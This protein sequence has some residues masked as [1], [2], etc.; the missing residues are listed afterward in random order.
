MLKHAVVI[1]EL[2]GKTLKN[3]ITDISLQ[4]CDIKKWLEALDIAKVLDLGNNAVIVLKT[5]APE[6]AAP[7]SKLF[8]YNHNTGIYLLNNVENCP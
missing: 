8:Q 7:L 2:T 6:L 5:Y 3:I 1:G 4:S